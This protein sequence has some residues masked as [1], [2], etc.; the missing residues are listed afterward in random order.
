[1]L[2]ILHIILGITKVTYGRRNVII[3]SSL[4]TS[5]AWWSYELCT[6]VAPFPELMWGVFTAY[7][8]FLLFPSLLSFEC[9]DA[10]AKSGLDMFGQ[11]QVSRELSPVSKVSRPEVHHK[12]AQIERVG[13]PPVR[14]TLCWKSRA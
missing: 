3:P 5:W 12:L 6:N 7:V 11:I 4:L 13:R 8:V 1:M 2:F 9:V 14:C 10:K